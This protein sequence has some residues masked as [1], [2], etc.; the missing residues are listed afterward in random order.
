MLKFLVITASALVFMTDLQ[1]KT[2]TIGVD[3]SGSNPLLTHENFAAS[4]ANYISQEIKSLQTGDTLRMKTFGAR[5]NV[6]NLLSFDV[7]ISRKARPNKVAKKISQTILAI[8]AQAKKMSQSHTALIAWLEFTPGF[9]CADGGKI[10]VLTD[11]I[12]SSTL[13]ST[14]DFV[15]K[16]KPLPKA[17]ISLKGCQITFYG[18]GAGLPTTYARHVRKSWHTWAGQAGAD[19][20]DIMK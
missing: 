9:D 13:I 20:N 1:A 8:P 6:Q 11:G 4:A 15:N 12:E 17:E 3:L 10:I 19:F 7:N 5:D 2:L 14:N 16:Q 18:L